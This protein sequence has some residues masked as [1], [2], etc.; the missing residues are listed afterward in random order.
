[1]IALYNLKKM[2][3]FAIAVCI[4][5]S[6]VL[7]FYFRMDAAME[8]AEKSKAETDFNIVQTLLDLKYPGPWNIRNGELYKD[9][10]NINNNFVLVDDIK[11]LT[12][13][14]C[15]VFLRNTCVA[16]TLWEDDC[17]RITG[18]YAP[19]EV[20]SKYFIGEQLYVERTRLAGKMQQIVY[21]PIRNEYREIIGVFCI[22]VP[23]SAYYTFSIA[24]K[25]IGLLIFIS[26]IA[27]L[28]IWFFFKRSVIKLLLRSVQRKKYIMSSET[29]ESV[30]READHC[31][32]NDSY[33]LNENEEADAARSE[34]P[35]GLSQ[36]TLDRILLFLKH[37]KDIEITVRNV[38]EALSLSKDTVRNYLEYLHKKGVIDIE[39][40]YGTVG[41]PLRVYIFK[42]IN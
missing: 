30:S 24:M 32:E 36:A 18:A 14:H 39:Q 6:M 9:K 2:I 22:Y 13:N 42:D 3:L 26:F 11:N 20:Y 25:I 16:T 38:S 35:K 31:P 21:K 7:H 37:Q 41:R 10:T 23:M 28:F 17:E 8:K 34:L 19:Y 1:M 40:K 5:M 29:H 12:G 33:R 4:T 15:A 27:T